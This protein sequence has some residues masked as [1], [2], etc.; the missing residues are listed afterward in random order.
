MSHLPEVS[1][2]NLIELM[3]VN[4]ELV[5]QAETQD[6]FGRVVLDMDS[7]ESPCK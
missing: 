1:E 5:T 4:R 7:T 2:E 6:D 3:A